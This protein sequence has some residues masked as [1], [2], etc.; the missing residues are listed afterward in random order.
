MITYRDR[1]RALEAMR[2][3]LAEKKIYTEKKLKSLL[4]F[5]RALLNEF[6]ERKAPSDNLKLILEIYVS[7]LKV[8]YDEMLSSNNIERK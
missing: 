3:I 5:A 8:A 2:I 7:F 4:S 1:E 6:N